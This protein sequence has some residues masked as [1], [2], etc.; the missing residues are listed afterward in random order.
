MSIV[1]VFALIALVVVVLV[2]LYGVKIYNGLVRNRQMV[3][4]GWSGIDVQLKRRT[5]LIPN[6]IAAVKGYMSHERDTLEE[7]TSLRARAQAVGD[8]KP[9]ERAQIEGML[10]ASLGRLL[11]IAENYPDLKAS[12]NFMELQQALQTIEDQIQLARR[13]YNGA[14]RQLNIHVEQFPSNIVAGM[15]GF[16]SAEFFEVDEPADR[17]VPTVS[18]DKA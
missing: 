10:T 7:V 13:Y 15:F 16:K 5:D 17:D 6:M 12:Q 11:A 8:D 1:L 4:E 18:F 9:A 14:V 2:L 3:K